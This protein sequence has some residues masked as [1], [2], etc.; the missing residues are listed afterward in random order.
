MSYNMKSTFFTVPV[1]FFILL[2][3][4]AV[5]PRQV[6]TTS[7]RVTVLD[8]LGNP[9][10]GAAVALYNNETDYERSE[11]PAAGPALSDDK[12]RVTFKDLHPAAY[13]MEVSKE[14]MSN[15]G[16]GNKTAVLEKN[17]LNRVN[18]IID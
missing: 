15:Y 17:K 18:V 16:G 14:D 3:L 10:Q 7:L 6:L 1:L 5:R 13:F 11:N 4:T 2:T 9:V 8:N 12:G